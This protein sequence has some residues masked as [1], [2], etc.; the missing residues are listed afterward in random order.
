MCYVW[1]RVKLIQRHGSVEIYTC[2]ELKKFFVRH[3]ITASSIFTVESSAYVIKNSADF[4]KLH[5]FAEEL[6]AQSLLLE[7]EVGACIGRISISDLLEARWSEA[8]FHNVLWYLDS[9]AGF[10]E[11][12][13]YNKVIFCNYA[14]TFSHL[15]SIVQPHARSVR[16]DPMFYLLRVA[17]SVIDKFKWRSE[18]NQAYRFAREELRKQ[19]PNSTIGVTTG[20]KRLLVVATINRSVERLLPAMEYLKA[21]GFE[22]SIVGYARVSALTK[23]SECGARCFHFGSFMAENDW[24]SVERAVRSKVRTRWQALRR[25]LPKGQHRWQGI[26]QIELA[27]KTL[28]RKFSVHAAQA[29]LA[30]HVADR[31]MRKIQPDLVLC[32]EDSELPRAFTRL[33]NRSGVPS[34]IYLCAVPNLHPGSLRFSQEQMFVCGSVAREMMLPWRADSRVIE[35]GDTLVDEL[36]TKRQQFK[37]ADF[38]RRHKLEPGQGVIGVLSSWPDDSILTLAEIKHQF[39]KSFEVSVR[40]GRPVAIKLHPL[41][42]EARVRSWIASLGIEAML[43]KDCNLLDFCFACDVIVAPLTTAIWQAMMAGIPVASFVLKGTNMAANAHAE[44]GFSNQQGV[45][46]IDHNEDP[47][48]VIS[49]LLLN[50]AKRAEQVKKGIAYVSMHV[51]GMD[52]LNSLKLTA[53]LD[54]MLASSGLA[55]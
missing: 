21:A 12:K 46:C 17:Y 49:E 36:D 26:D 43:L 29:E 19:N 47:T 51:G 16:F 55:S 33:A 23:L 24:S 25:N 8:L 3:G 54:H 42:D 53:A 50:S 11:N 10:V 18:V 34:A 48:K 52:G 39:L 30:F 27:A 5:L 2:E 28:K 22:V 45:R 41:Q 6:N 44:Y 35:V 9:F 15:A 32:F 1:L 38:W 31:A 4:R 14:P 20:R 40:L 13:S 37:R 7:D